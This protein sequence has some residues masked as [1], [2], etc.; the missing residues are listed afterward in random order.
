MRH[1]RDRQCA[2]KYPRGNCWPH[3]IKYVRVC[4]WDGSCSEWIYTIGSAPYPSYYNMIFQTLGEALTSATELRAIHNSL[5][6]PNAVSL[7]G[8]DLPRGE[9]EDAHHFVVYL[10]VHGTL[11]ELDGLKRAAVSHGPIEGSWMER[12]AGVIARRI[13]MY[14]AGSVRLLSM[15]HLCSPVPSPC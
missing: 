12:A 7:D 11:H 5:S 6:P 13:D 14:P 9:A 2:W 8:L 1:H 10:P 15:W 4:P 3:T